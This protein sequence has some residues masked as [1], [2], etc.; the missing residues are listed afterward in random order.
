MPIALALALAVALILACPAWGH[1]ASLQAQRA[2]AKAA[3]DRRPLDRPGI[4]GLFACGFARM[5]PAAAR[6]WIGPGGSVRFA[7]KPVVA[8]TQ[9]MREANIAVMSGKEGTR[10]RGNGLPMHETGNFPIGAGTAAA[11]WDRNPNRI[12]PYKLAVDLPADPQVAAQPS[13]LPMGV[14]GVA[15]TGAVFFNAL[16]A[17][18][19]DAVAHEIMDACEGHPQQNGQYHYHHGSPCFDNGAT[20]VHSP[21]IGFALDG[22]GIYGPR[23]EG[24]RPVTNDALDECHGHL[25]PVPMADGTTRMVYHYHANSEFPY[26]LG[27]FRGTPGDG[28][29]R[30]PAVGISLPP[31]PPP[32]AGGPP[33]SGGGPAPRGLAGPPPGGPPPGQLRRSTG[34]GQGGPPPGAPPSGTPPPQPPS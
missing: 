31:A 4:N 18:G 16:D 15:L 22:F 33:S 11:A 12:L 1:D 30:P 19:R 10:I 23:D 28:R 17:D 24:G 27:C 29:A 21:L 26:T 14:I 20:D 3:V 9:P 25:G 2:T 32:A 34:T 7:D 5:G 8:G 6:P 13:C